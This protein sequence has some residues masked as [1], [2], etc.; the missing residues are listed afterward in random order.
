[1]KETE[2][3]MNGTNETNSNHV[4][5]NEVENI[6]ILTKSIETIEIPEQDGNDTT[7]DPPLRLLLQ[8]LIQ[9]DTA[10]NTILT[11]VQLIEI[12][13]KQF[14]QDVYMM[15]SLEVDMY[16]N[17]MKKFLKEWP[18]W[19]EFDE[20]IGNLKNNNDQEGIKNVLEEKYK[21][22]TQYLK[23]MID[24]AKPM[25]DE[26]VKDL[27]EEKPMTLLD[28]DT[29]VMEVVCT[30]E[31][32]NQL[33]YRRP[34]SDV[35]S[36]V[37]N[38]ENCLHS[39]IHLDTWN[40]TSI[41]HMWNV[42]VGINLNFLTY[43]REMLH[44]LKHILLNKKH[45][46]THPLGTLNRDFQV[47]PTRP[48]DFLRNQ[49]M[50][51]FQTLLSMHMDG[52]NYDLLNEVFTVLK[53]D[54]DEAPDVLNVPARYRRYMNKYPYL[55]HLYTEHSDR[56]SDKFSKSYDLQLEETVMP[57][58][59]ICISKFEITEIEL[60]SFEDWFQ[61]ECGYCKVKFHGDDLLERLKT[62]FNENHQNE[63][64]WMCSH[65]LGKFTM[66]QLTELKWYHSC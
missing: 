47:K 2:T 43:K 37:F 7:E 13:K 14:D 46:L 16:M 56:V 66:K 59:Q 52:D 3:N 19:D 61:I 29:V 53:S 48:K 58:F 10:Q 42:K 18:Q 65:C 49:L 32:L 50:E 45:T 36:A 17:I 21:D 24:L 63:P 31:Q 4:P 12:L 39:R 44:T 26:A 28:T 33:F 25:I 23:S 40:L 64:E 6:E 57:M 30:R 11:N 8:R 34:K 1:M 35:S 20:V 55:R 38:I 15:H 27:K 54:F 60:P 41:L 5:P 9:N 22:L 62:H 51:A